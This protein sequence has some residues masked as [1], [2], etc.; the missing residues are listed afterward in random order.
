M[1]RYYKLF[2]LINR[3]EMKK[4]DLLQIMSSKTLA[5][6][7]KGEYINGKTIDEICLFLKCQPNDIMEVF[8]E[9]DT[10]TEKIK[11]KPELIDIAE[12]TKMNTLQKMHE[13]YE[14]TKKEMEKRES[15]N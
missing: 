14:K 2:D 9:I 15:Q 11:I 3:K 13:D 12:E 7:S 5:K 8:E 1:I 10:G 4:T 6:L